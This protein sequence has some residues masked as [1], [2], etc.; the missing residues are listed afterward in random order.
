MRDT[1]ALECTVDASTM[2]AVVCGP[3]YIFHGPS[4][5]LA[6]LSKRPSVAGH[7]A[8]VDPSPMIQRKSSR[9]E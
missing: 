6:R 1:L 3:G 8:A 4:D 7:V 2:G 9:N 5:A